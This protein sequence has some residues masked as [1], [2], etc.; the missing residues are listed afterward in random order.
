MERMT[1]NEMTKSV[2]MSMIDVVGARGRPL[3]KWGDTVLEYVRER[4][5]RRMRVFQ[6]ASREC[7]DRNKW[8]LFCRGH[9]LI[10]GVLRNRRQI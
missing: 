6:H 3:V 5:E 9:P 1:E 7:S 2:Y 10:G 8:R 4:G